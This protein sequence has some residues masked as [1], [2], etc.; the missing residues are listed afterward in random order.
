LF[1]S[2]QSGFGGEQ[3]SILRGGE[4]ERKE[5]GKETCHDADG[6]E[7]TVGGDHASDMDDDEG[8]ADVPRR[9]GMG[10]CV[11]VFHVIHGAV[12]DCPGWTGVETKEERERRGVGRGVDQE[13]NKEKRKRKEMR[14]EEERGA[15]V[16]KG[17]GGEDD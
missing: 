10:T 15:T 14:E 6:H 17:K 12:V 2:S 16:G 11:V 1:S 7:D 8:V 5:R 13:W 3:C 4:R 9:D